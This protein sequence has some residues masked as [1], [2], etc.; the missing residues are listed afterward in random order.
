MKKIISVIIPCY[1]VEAYLDRCLLSVINQ[2][3]GIE[4]FEIICIDDHSTDNTL[5][6]L[7]S[8]EKE[9]PESICVIQCQQ[10]G[11]Q[12]TARNIGLSYANT[13]WIAFVDSD[14][15]LEEDY[16][17][18]LYHIAEDGDFDIVACDSMRDD[19]IVYR[20]ATQEER[21]K[22]DISRDISIKTIDERKRLMRDNMLKYSAWGRLIR[23]SFLIDNDI[24]FPEGLVYEDIFWGSLIN[25]YVERFYLL[26]KRLY[27][28]FVNTKSTVLSCDVDSHLDMLTVNELL[29]NEVIKRGFSLEYSNEMEWELFYSGLLA[30]FKVI[31]LRYA[32]VS[33]SMYRLL[34]A[35]A[36]N[37]I[38]NPESNS[39]YLS[40]QLSEIHKIIIDSL[41]MEMTRADF[42]EMVTYIKKTGI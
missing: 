19:S 16:L 22:S 13:E 37:H 41:Y 29:W 2:T 5:S 28:Y 8:W 21:E 3:I 15:W 34:C 4:K 20:L 6:K 11:R 24:Y 26:E 14:D 40:G 9:Y 35:F 23:K 30:F 38:K 33:Y 7:M 27:H 36:A 31:V 39:Y 17:E 1:N 10:N 42:E 32:K 18:Q 12:G 25:Y